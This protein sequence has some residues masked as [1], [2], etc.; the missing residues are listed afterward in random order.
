MKFEDGHIPI[1][2]LLLHTRVVL[3][4]YNVTTFLESFAMDIPTIMFWNPEH[5]ELRPGAVP[6]FGLLE[7]AGLLFRRPA[8]AALKLA[9]VWDDVDGWWTSEP[10]R[11]ARQW[12]M[13]L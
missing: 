9:E 6:A 10:V 8:D 4:S 3:Y 11:S 1:R 12:N 13:G 2:D 7:E 5:W